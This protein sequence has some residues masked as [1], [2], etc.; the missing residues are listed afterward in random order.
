MGPVPQQSGGS[1]DSGR[2]RSAHEAGEHCL[3]ALNVYDDHVRKWSETDI[4]SGRVLANMATG[5]IL[6]ASRLGEADRLNE[7][8]QNALDSRIVIEQAK[9]ILAGEH[10]VSVDDG[11]EILRQHARSNRA[12]LRDVADAVVKIGLRPEPSEPR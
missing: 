4:E 11:F 2:T 3:G 1:R 6:H 7:Q 10:G 9:G 12:S 8:L 5:Y